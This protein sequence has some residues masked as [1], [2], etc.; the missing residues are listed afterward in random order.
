[1]S[2]EFSA[3]PL[4]VEVVY[5]VRELPNRVSLDGGSDMLSIVPKH[6]ISWT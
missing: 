4:L 1:M 6:S 5:V 2:V 3:F